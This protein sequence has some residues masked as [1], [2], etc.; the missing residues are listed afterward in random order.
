MMRSVVAAGSL[1]ACLAVAGCSA[2]QSQPA[3]PPPDNFTQVMGHGIRYAH[4]YEGH[5]CFTIDL[6]GNDWTMTSAS[7]ER[8]LWK[9][10]KT[11]V[12]NLYL[13]DNRR[14]A[15]AVAGMT[16]E[17]ALRAFIGSELA[18][19][20][21]RFE[22]QSV[23]PPRFARDPNG[24]WSQ[25]SWKGQGGI[26]ARDGSKPSDQQ[27]VI[28]SLWLDPWVLSFDFASRELTAHMG[29]TPE[30]IDILES[31]T[32]YPQC[33]ATM[34]PGETYRPVVIKKGPAPTSKRP[35]AKPVTTSP[36]RR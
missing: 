20:K 26:Q 17:E 30:M 24:L 35:T 28:A 14:A 3:G 32:F 31:L 7:S 13:T 33:F 16:E 12:L 10:G 11:D 2:Q 1:L 4:N 36:E 29:P 19:V 15:F 9:R 22:Y 21:P 18:Y 6:P 5:P 25:W 8:V 34:R 23:R 27:H